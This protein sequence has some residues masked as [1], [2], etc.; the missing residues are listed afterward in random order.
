MRHIIDKTL[1][2]ISAATANLGGAAC[3]A[4]IVTFIAGQPVWFGV[5]AT[6]TVVLLTISYISCRFRPRT[7]PYN[8]QA[9]KPFIEEF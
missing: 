6:A 4:T 7:S 8:Y 1:S 9:F 3:Y 2:Y 5:S